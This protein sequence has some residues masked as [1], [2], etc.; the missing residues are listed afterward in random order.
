MCTTLGAPG[1][2]AFS[3]EDKLKP[4]LAEARK[5]KNSIYASDL[6]A[7]AFIVTDD[8]IQPG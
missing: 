3:F 1:A 5:D 2:Q 7:E 6:F 4:L 8:F